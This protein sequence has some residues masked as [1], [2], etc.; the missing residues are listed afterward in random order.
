[1]ASINIK[2]NKN[3]TT[4]YNKLLSEYGEEFTKLNG[5]SDAQLSYTDFID[6]FIDS[7]NVANASVDS[8]ANI[9]QKILLLYYQKCQSL[10]KSYQL[11]INFIMN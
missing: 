7:N 2:L 11:L 1:M 10:I 9:A 4:Q 8:N 5:F 6:A 3:F